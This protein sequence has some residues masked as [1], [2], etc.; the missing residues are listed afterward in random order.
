MMFMEQRDESKPKFGFD[1]RHWEK[2]MKE[3]VNQVYA[4]VY[5]RIEAIKQQW[6]AKRNQP[7]VIQQAQQTMTQRML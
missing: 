3:V 4:K 5:E 2:L 7:I 6:L 1:K